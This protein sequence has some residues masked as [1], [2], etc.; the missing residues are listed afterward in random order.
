MEKVEDGSVIV[1]VRMEQPFSL[2]K[3]SPIENSHS[4]KWKVYNTAALQSKNHEAIDT[5]V[6][7]GG[8][9]IHV[10][11]KYIFSEACRRKGWGLAE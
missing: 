5:N 6:Q 2:Y 9:T 8:R 10:V 11:F 7:G 4:L 3:K 1:Y